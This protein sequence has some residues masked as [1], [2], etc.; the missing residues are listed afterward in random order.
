MVSCWTDSENWE[1]PF[2]LLTSL[3]SVFLDLLESGSAK[4][5]STG[6]NSPLGKKNN[7]TALVKMHGCNVLSAWTLKCK[8]ANAKAAAAFVVQ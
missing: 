4:R 6:D 3:Q 2:Q 1:K 7:L 5:N 8:M